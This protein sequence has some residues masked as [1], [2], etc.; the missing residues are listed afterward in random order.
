MNHVRVAYP[1]V[2][3]RL[4]D[5]YENS[6][7]IQSLLGAY[8]KVGDLWPNGSAINATRLVVKMPSRKRMRAKARASP[9]EAHINA[10]FFH[11]ASN[12]IHIHPLP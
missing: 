4:L 8:K 2:H 11:T 7:P 6:T 9:K 10:H 3:V 12:L 1:N 5:A